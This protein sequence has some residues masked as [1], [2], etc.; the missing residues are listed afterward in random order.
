MEYDLRFAYSFLLYWLLPLVG[1]CALFV[2]WYKRSVYYRYPLADILKRQHNIDAT[3]RK[4]ILFFLRF[5]SVIIL[6]FLVAKPQLVDQRSKMRVD[7]IDI[8]LVLDVSGSMETVDVENDNRS[9]V[10]VAKNEA[11]RFINKR[12]N[13]AIGLVIFGKD[14]ISRCPLTLDRAICKDIIKSLHIGTVDPDGTALSTAIIMAANRLKNS[15]AKSK[16]MIVLTDGEPSEEDADPT[17]AIEVAKRLGIKIYTVGIGGDEPMVVGRS[18][19]GL[20]IRNGINKKL[21]TQFASA[22]G[23]RF[24]EARNAKDMRAIYD[25]IDTLEKTEHETLI[26][27]KTYD[28]FMPFLLLAAA[29]LAFELLLSSFVWFGI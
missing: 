15:T 23:G 3:Y 27:N 4:K 7:G 24:F 12:D 14:A 9:R 21:L 19:M 25:T 8:M 29:L 17:I 18:L 1:V 16:V 13:D 26:F 28:I 20:L 5:F 10:E 11:I 6:A 2:C 22:T